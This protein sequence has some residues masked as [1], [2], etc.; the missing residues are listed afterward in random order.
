[1]RHHE[2]GFAWL[3]KTLATGIAVRPFGDTDQRNILK[4]QFGHHLHGDAQLPFAAVNQHQIGAVGAGLFDAG[5]LEGTM[6]KKLKAQ[7]VPIRAIHTMR[8]ATKAW[9]ARSGLDER[10]TKALRQALLEIDDERAL[11]ALRFDGFLP[12]Q[13]ADYDATREAITR[14]SEFFDPNS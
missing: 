13:D 11:T 1:M 4:P 2:I 3:E 6:F 7:G 14:N 5:A 12:G 10:I 8:N 9:V